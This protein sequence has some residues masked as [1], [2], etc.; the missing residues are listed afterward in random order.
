MVDPIEHVVA[1]VLENQSFDRLVGLT[2]R[3]DG[4]DP[5]APRSNPDSEQSTTILQNLATQATDYNPARMDFDPK[6]DYDDVRQQIQGPCE[7]FVDNFVQNYRTGNPREIMAYYDAD[8]L[9]ALNALATQFVVCD[10]WFCSVPG[11]T[12]PNRFYINAGTSLGHVDMPS[13]AHFDPALHKYDQP[14]IFER[15]SEA[16]P[17]ID[18]RIYFHDFSQTTLLTQQVRYAANYRYMFSF[19]E[20]C[21]DAA[22]FPQYAFL[23]PKYFWPEENDQ[24]PTSDIRRG[25]ALIASVYNALL[26]NEELWN[27]TLFV[28]LYDEHGG[29][30]DH[31]DPSELPYKV[32]AVPPDAHTT[33]PPDNFAFDLFGPRVAAVLVS[34]WLDSGVLH[35]VYDHTS[36]LKYLTQKWTLGTLGNR[37]AAANSFAGEIIWRAT[38]R[39]IA[40]TTFVIPDIPEDPKPTGLSE[41]QEALVSFSRYLE[42]QMASQ[43]PEGPQKE[44]FLKAVGQRL[45]TTVEDVTKHG[46]VAAERLRLFLNSQGATLPPPVSS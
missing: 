36:L 23:E 9:P 41:G 10:R 7:G 43:T 44:N 26:G 16:V 32:K 39:T 45:L 14:T 27:S 2:P 15:L 4:V 13:L 8:Y 35:G 24:H 25:D 37:V 20:D 12:W 6:H 22:T 1:L 19:Y 40:P 17:K 34:P 21:K 28:I 46:A 11:P 5:Q 30:Y 38:V 3:V 42:L 31:V 18:W 33:P 29:F